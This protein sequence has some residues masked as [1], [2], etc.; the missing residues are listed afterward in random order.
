MK[1]PVVGPPAPPVGL[2]AAAGFAA[3]AGAGGA[4]GGAGGAFTAAVEA[5]TL[6][7]FGPAEEGRA[8]AGFAAAVFPELASSFAA[9]A[10]AF[11]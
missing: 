1:R 9:I 5:D 11:A 6:P 8:A 3:A 2:G 7:G 10:A 4:A